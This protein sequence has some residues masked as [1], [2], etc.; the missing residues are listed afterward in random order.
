MSRNTYVS[1]QI[2][3]PSQPK[4]DWRN[5]ISSN[6]WLHLSYS[7]LTTFCCL[8]L[9][10][11]SQAA[12]SPNVELKIGI[13]QRFGD[14]PIDKLNL[15]ATPG[16]RLTLKFKTGE[17][18]QTLQASSAKLEVV[19]QTLPLPAVEERVVLSTHRSFETAENSAEQWRKKGIEVEIA[20][21]ERWQVWAKRKVYNTPLLRR[22]LLRSV[23]AKGN[24]TAYVDTQILQQIPQ[25]SLVVNGYRYSRN[26]LDI[27]TSK[28]LIRVE[29]NKRDTVY[30]GSLHLQPNAYGTYTLVNNVPLETYLRGV[31]PHEIGAN[32]P[33]AAVEAQAII[34]RTYALR[35]LRRFA[36]DGY[37]LCAD[38]HCQ[39]YRGLSGTVQN[40]DRAIAATRGQ[41]LTYKNELVDALY[42][43][44]TGGITATF[45]DVWNGADRAYL[46]P[47]VDAAGN[48]WNLD[49]QT[50]AD[51]NNFQRFISLRQ[52][53]NETGWGMFRWR[54][55][56]SMEQITKD[57]Q[58][59]LE[60][61]KNPMAFKKIQQIHVVERSPSGRILKLAVQTDRGIFV[62]EK[63]EVR[64]AFSAPRST[65]F[66]LE[67]LT[68]G[69]TLWGYAF[70]GGGLGH[71]VGLSQTGSQRLAQL[72]WSSSRILNFYYPTTQIQPLSDQITFWSQP[73][74]TSQK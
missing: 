53:F 11:R 26:E 21:P 13:L 71:G 34:A 24:K 27:T 7:V 62:L 12:I 18:Q 52:G 36:L 45:S 10:A 51:E 57:L 41:V 1:R 23:Q 70:V 46:Q 29:G 9:T 32:A 39:V 38:T 65:L 66:Y 3:T 72:G 63:D 44:T 67:P 43:S 56:S 17:R 42:S 68:K 8:G 15:E 4:T 61:N 48:V 35:N 55:E 28:T 47:I 5:L 73:L 31:V 2:S 30:A 22:L 25:T 54:K 60:V 37:E 40:A 19:M 69:N 14:E 74:T 20:Q 64:N 59:Y 33:Y 6:I 50:L 16:D 58:H 49:R